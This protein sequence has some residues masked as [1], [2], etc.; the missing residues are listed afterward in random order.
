MNLRALTVG[1]LVGGIALAGGG[2]ASASPAEDEA[3]VSLIVGLRAATDVVATLERSVDVVGSE[4]LAGAVTVDVPAGQVAEAAEALRA[5]PAVAYVER[6]RIARIA[7]VTPDDP[8]FRHQWGIGK[9]GVATA[10]Q[11]TRGSAATVVAVVDTGVTVLP[12]LAGRVLPGRD[13]VNKDANAADDQG[14]GTMTAGVIA[15]RGDNGIGIAGICW[16]CQIL[17][18]KVLGA[19]GSGSY[20]DIAQ[21]IRWAADQGADIINLSLGGADDSQLLRDAV[22]Y[23]SG[24]G[25]LVVA[26]AG[27]DG[28]SAPH[29][30]AAIPAVLAV[31][32]STVTDSRYSWSNYGRSWVDIAAPGC[33]PA[34]GRDGAVA[35]FCGTSSATPFVS[36]VAALL[37]STA[38]TPTAAVLRTALTT[39]AHGIAGTWVPTSSGRI[40]APAA[41]ASLPVTDDEVPPVTSF[42]SPGGNTLV[43][44]TVTVA[45]AATDDIGV[46]KVQ[47]LADG[48][49]VGTDRVAPYRFS[50]PTGWRRKGVTLGLRTY[51]RGGNVTSATRRVMV[52]NWGPAVQITGGPAD[53][54]RR[55]RKTRY[56]T[57]TATDGSGV[58]R[59]ELLVDGKV[60]ERYAGSAH[61]FAVQTWKHG[62]SLTV[63]V[64]AYDKAGNVRYAPA[65]KWYR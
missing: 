28:S 5:D 49:V 20:S 42:L 31:G 9:A 60:T 41:L 22:A 54:A 63:R 10:W 44:G 45:A 56:V 2:P 21:G 14:H 55:V 65:R 33:N 19:K 8:F 27:N 43:H 30:P 7:A 64:R 58:S 32:A 48:V 52:D 57:A 4:A 26:A 13:F 40:D 11:T 12:D 50:W 29:Y 51:D 35:M 18:V 15:A 36:G 46:A 61:R 3:A 24:K 34:Q 38:P 62:A 16:T 1:L 53:G 17:P 25:A 47:L 6:D 39:S 23:A 37:A 59:L